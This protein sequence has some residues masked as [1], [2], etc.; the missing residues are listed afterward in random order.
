MSLYMA[1]VTWP[2]SRVA[3][4]V[5]GLLKVAIETPSLGVA[6][7]EAQQSTNGSISQEQTQGVIFVAIWHKER[8]AG[9]S[10]FIE[11]AALGAVEDGGSARVNTISSSAV[12]AVL[13][14]ILL[15]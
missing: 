7:C 9:L 12:V 5:A 2:R 3:P 13:C 11:V 10:L 1:P 14:C 15:C 6:W 4:A 8:G